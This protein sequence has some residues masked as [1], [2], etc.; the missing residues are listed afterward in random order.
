M[1]AAQFEPSLPASIL[2]VVETHSGS[3][4]GKAA[5][6]LSTARITRAHNHEAQAALFWGE[7]IQLLDD[8]KTVDL[9]ALFVKKCQQRIKA[10]DRLK[11]L[12]AK[13]EQAEAA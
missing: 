12:L 3:G 1:R 8:G 6:L 4:S 2:N 10:A 13:V 7:C 9:R 5:F 11:A